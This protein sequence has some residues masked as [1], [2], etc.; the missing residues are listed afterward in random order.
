MFK[1]PSVVLSLLLLAGCATPSLRAP[2]NME[3]LVVGPDSRGFVLAES[4]KPF[5]P[6]G[7]NYG[8]NGR[9]IED[10]WDNDWATVAADFQKPKGLGANVLRI[11]LQFGKFMSAPDRPNRAALRQLSRLLLLAEETG[12]YLDL[13][14]LASYRPGDTP[15]WYNAMDERRRWSAQS[16]FWSAVADTCASSPAV[17]CYDLMNEPVSPGDKRKPGEWAAG[18]FGGMDFVQCITLD[19]GKRKREDVAVQWIRTMTA[20]IR[21]HDARALITVGL[22]PWDP[23]WGHLSGFIPDKIAPELGFISVHIYPE[24]KQPDLAMAALRKCAVGKPVV[25]EET[26]PLSCGSEQE[27]TFLLASKAIA[28]GWIGHYDGLNLADYDALERAGKLTLAQSIY[29]DWQRL[30]VKLKPELAGD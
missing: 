29:R 1:R 25:I 12:I 11:H 2:T 5:H 27:E 4:K 10:F 26:F 8:N 9:L 7:F 28:C 23:N 16:N 6:W 18:S 14:G 13:T 24:T 21:S 30:F 3:R 22:L 19:P 15:R 20:A 17:F